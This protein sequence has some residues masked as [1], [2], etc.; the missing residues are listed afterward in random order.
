MKPSKYNSIVDKNLIKI[1]SIFKPDLRKLI[2]ADYKLY[3]NYYRV[4]LDEFEGQN[5]LRQTFFNSLER[6]TYFDNRWLRR[7]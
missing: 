5:E 7:N 2:E 4:Y 3:Q 6:N 1:I